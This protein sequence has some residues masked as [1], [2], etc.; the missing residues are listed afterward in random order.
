MII[1]L[2]KLRCERCG[3]KWIPRKEE[4]RIC[5]KCKSPYWNRKR[6]ALKDLEK[7]KKKGGEKDHG[8]RKKKKR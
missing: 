2:H 8:L 4:V 3:H 1:K 6:K 5:P 7:S